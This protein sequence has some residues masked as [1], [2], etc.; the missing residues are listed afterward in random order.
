MLKKRNVLF[1]AAVLSPQ[2]ALLLRL[3]CQLTVPVKAVGIAGVN[4]QRTYKQTH[5]ANLLTF[6]AATGHLASV[7]THATRQVAGSPPPSPYLQ[8]GVAGEIP[9]PPAARYGGVL[10]S[11]RADALVAR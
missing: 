3:I 2:T 7:Y 11:C 5:L 6:L 9:P 4:F 8:L 1:L 10:L